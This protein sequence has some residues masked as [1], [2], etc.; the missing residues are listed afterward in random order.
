M[1][2]HRHALLH[3]LQVLLHEALALRG[4]LCLLNPLHLCVH[5]LHV[6]LHLLHLRG[7]LRRLGLFLACSRRLSGKHGRDKQQDD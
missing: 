3:A 2:H 6:G 1:P 7:L 5:R 4:I